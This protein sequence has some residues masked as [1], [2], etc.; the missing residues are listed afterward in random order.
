MLQSRQPFL[1]HIN[2]TSLPL[3]SNSQRKADD[4]TTRL[5]TINIPRFGGGNPFPNLG[6]T[7]PIIGETLQHRSPEII[8]QKSRTILCA[9]R[10]Q[11]PFL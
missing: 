5:G 9:R 4:T 1:K 8:A 2:T 11:R 7:L 6:I 10:R 3:L